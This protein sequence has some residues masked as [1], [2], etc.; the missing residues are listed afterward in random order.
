M[1]WPTVVIMIK[2]DQ[3]FWT[4]APRPPFRVEFPAK[5]LHPFGD[6]QNHRVKYAFLPGRIPLPS[7]KCQ[8]KTNAARHLFIPRNCRGIARS[9]VHGELVEPQADDHATDLGR[10]GLTTTKRPSRRAGAIAKSFPIAKC[11]AIAW[12]PSR[13]SREGGNPEA[14]LTKRFLPATSLDSRLRGKDDARS[15]EPLDFAIVLADDP[16]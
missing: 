5:W 11:L 4:T 8:L 12:P 9:P 7:N 14:R 10:T 6:G 1:G 16:G 15:D 3:R 13:L 2:R